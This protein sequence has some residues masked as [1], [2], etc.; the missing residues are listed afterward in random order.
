VILFGFL[1]IGCGSD[2]CCDGEK[3]VQSKAITGELVDQRNEA[4]IAII[5]NMPTSVYRCREVSASASTSY[6]TDGNISNYVWSV[7]DQNI[8]N[9]ENFNEVLSCEDN[10]TNIEV[11]LNVIDNNGTISIPTC[12][13]VKIVDDEVD[14]KIV[15][16]FSLPTFEIPEPIRVEN[17]HIF[18]I[19]DQSF[20]G[21]EIESYY[22]QVTKHYKDG[23][24]AT[25]TN[26]T[27]KKYIYAYQ[28]FEK[29]DVTLTLTFT[30]GNK[31]S[32]T[33]SYIKSNDGERLN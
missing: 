4:P 20:D 24:S 30:D 17:Q 33:N 22:W 2:E 27:C 3:L 32:A 23:S 18:D 16:E 25:H 9:D 1:L 10:Q 7:L 5:T 31:T 29:L 12:Q 14:D 11:C 6:D 13:V 8:S 26:D 15:N 21:F 28:D 19:C